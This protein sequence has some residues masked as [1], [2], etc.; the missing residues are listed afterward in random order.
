MRT[1]AG[2]E[3]GE[4]ETGES[5]STNMYASTNL[6]YTTHPSLNTSLSKLGGTSLSELGVCGL[7]YRFDHL[8]IEFD[9]SG[10]PLIYVH[11][12][13]YLRGRSHLDGIVSEA[14]RTLVRFQP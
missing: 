12:I 10:V 14:P 11:V 5:D 9:G 3:R 6:Y 2:G 4:G 1:G 8:G 13:F 7:Y